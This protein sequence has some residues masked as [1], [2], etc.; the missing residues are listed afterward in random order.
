MLSK[1]TNVGMLVLSVDVAAESAS[2]SSSISL[3][4]DE[5]PR[6]AA[7]TRLLEL[8]ESLNLSATWAID[9]WTSQGLIERLR[10]ATPPQDMAILAD[11]SWASP[12]VPR[13]RFGNELSQRLGQA[14][15]AGCTIRT[16][17]LRGTRE[18]GQPDLL[19]KHGIVAI[20]NGSENTRARRWLSWPFDVRAT[21]VSGGPSPRMV[22]YGVWELPRGTVLEG[23]HARKTLERAAAVAARGELA[24]LVIEG[25]N[26]LGQPRSW[27][28]LQQTLRRAEQLRNSERLHL[29]S[30][31]E[32][33]E[34]LCPQQPRPHARS[35]LRPAA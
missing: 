34:R 32:A 6:A 26:Q 4:S 8:F 24:P 14:R 9:D 27:K 1:S 30:I 33:V 12:E 10:D 23:R 25:A 35:I 28:Q 16:I 11:A 2:A 17:A 21:R 18:V 13:R 22:R 31:A 20:R 7:W 29:G 15:T 19:A 3:S 5:Q